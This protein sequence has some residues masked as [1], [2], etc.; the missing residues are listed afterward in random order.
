MGVSFCPPT[1]LQSGVEAAWE[2]NPRTSTQAVLSSWRH[3]P[4]ASLSFHA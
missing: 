2:C 3:R 4:S 1:S